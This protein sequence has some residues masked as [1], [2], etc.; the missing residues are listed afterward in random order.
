[1][2]ETLKITFKKYVFNVGLLAILLVLDRD[3]ATPPPPDTVDA[4]GNRSI[5][6]HPGRAH[7]FSAAPCI[8]GAV[9]QLKTANANRVFSIFNRHRR[10]CPVEVSQML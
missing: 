7:R 4:T 10:A 3:H 9:C 8:F 1:V 5:R 6:G 2:D